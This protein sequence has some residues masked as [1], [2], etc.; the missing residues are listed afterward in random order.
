[1]YSCVFGVISTK[2]HNCIYIPKCGIFVW[3]YCKFCGMCRY[4]SN[5]YFGGVTVFTGLGGKYGVNAVECESSFLGYV[6]LL[7]IWLK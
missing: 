1:M 6:P 2:N 4:I 7:A 5:L 3:Y